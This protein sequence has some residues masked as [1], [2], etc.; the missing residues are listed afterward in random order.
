MEYAAGREKPGA[1]RLEFLLYL[2]IPAVVR[3]DTPRRLDTR[4]ALR[5]LLTG[6]M[7]LGM[8]WLIFVIVSRLDTHSPVQ[9]L[10]TQL[11]IYFTVAGLFNLA[12]VPLALRG[13][14]YDDPFDNPLASR[15]PGE[16]WGR[17]WNTW[18]N[19]LLYRYI[20]TPM[21][22]RK[23]PIRGALA[24][25][26]FSGAFHEAIVGV[27]TLS[28]PGWMFAYFLTQGLLVMATLHWRSFRHLAKRAPWLTWALTVTVMLATGVMFVRGAAGIDPSDAWNRVS[29]ANFSAS[30]AVP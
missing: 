21:R 16:F 7:Q 4:R 6:L 23:H 19:H 20:F 15:T 29:Q 18:V 3:W 17:R 27:A 10:T 24:A 2:I 26:A 22:G 28:F 13:L 25:F 8:L 1:K 9:L 5:A 12:V 14:D 30:A 11:G